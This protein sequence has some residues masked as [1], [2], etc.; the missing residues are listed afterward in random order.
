MT[1]GSVRRFQSYRN[2]ETKLNRDRIAFYILLTVE[3]SDKNVPC[4][5]CSRAMTYQGIESV[6]P[7][8]S[9]IRNVPV[10]L[11]PICGCKGWYD[12]KLQKVTE[13]Q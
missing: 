6:G 2:A 13:I 10:Y 12:E 3:T 4:P 5:R 1:G 8:A 7:G 11:C 9:R